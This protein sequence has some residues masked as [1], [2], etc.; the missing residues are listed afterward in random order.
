MAKISASCVR[1]ATICF[2]GVSYIGKYVTQRL[3]TAF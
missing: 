1:A 3:D 2:L